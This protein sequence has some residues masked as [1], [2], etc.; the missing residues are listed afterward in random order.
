M[1]NL[2]VP[3]ADA[4]S[5]EGYIRQASVDRSQ[6]FDWASNQ[7]SDELICNLYFAG[8]PPK[9]HGRLELR[10]PVDRSKFGG[11]LNIFWNGQHRVF[12]IDLTGPAHTNDD[13]E[14]VP[15]PHWHE[16]RD[17]GALVARPFRPPLAPPK[18]LEEAYHWTCRCFGITVVNPWRWPENLQGRFPGIPVRQVR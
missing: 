2:P 5:F 7:E 16:L 6:G 3:I 18:D 13:L 17:D 4:L 15:T 9:V 8:L 12:G 11:H 14:R 10:M 1:R